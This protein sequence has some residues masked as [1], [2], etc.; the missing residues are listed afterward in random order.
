MIAKTRQR[1]KAW[2]NKKGNDWMHTSTIK[3]KRT[4][5]GIAGKNVKEKENTKKM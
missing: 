1:M 4:R 3:Q 5:R 2:D